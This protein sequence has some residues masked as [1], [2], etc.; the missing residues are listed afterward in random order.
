MAIERIDPKLCN[1]C[2]ICVNSCMLDVIRVDEENETATIRY[3]EDCMMC[4]FCE[5]DCPEDAITI[6]EAKNSPLVVSWG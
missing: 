6:S 1:G 2:G 4:Y 3:P 5:Q